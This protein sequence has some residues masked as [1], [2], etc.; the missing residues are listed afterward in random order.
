MKVERQKMGSLREHMFDELPMSAAPK[1]VLDKLKQILVWFVDTSVEVPEDEV[2]LEILKNISSC[3]PT[4]IDYYEVW[5]SALE[6][7]RCLRYKIRIQEWYTNIW[8]GI[9]EN[10]DDGRDLAGVMAA[11][12]RE[13]KQEY[14]MTNQLMP[15]ELHKAEV[16]TL[17][18][19]Y[20]IQRGRG[21]VG[22][23]A[24]IC[25]SKRKEAT[26]TKG[27]EAVSSRPTLKFYQTSHDQ[28]HPSTYEKWSSDRYKQSRERGAD[29][30]NNEVDNLQE[31]DFDASVLAK[32]NMIA[33]RYC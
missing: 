5:M 17:I 13:N 32:P 7:D 30:V 20:C 1:M 31:G 23:H 8:K 25:E 27:S 18:I 26:N 14:A 28:D 6:W 10:S 2:I 33:Q 9:L 19:E 29:T 16:I 4:F 24:E 11:I 21:L 22:K 15:D 12:Y 3:G